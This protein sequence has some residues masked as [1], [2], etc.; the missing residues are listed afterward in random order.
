MERNTQQ[1][2]AILQAFSRNPTPLS[3]HEILLAAKRYA[4]G[5]GIATVYRSI[6]SMLKEGHLVPVKLPGAP[7]RYEP[8]GKLHHH[9]FE[10]K[11]CGRVFEVKRCT[12]NLAHIAPRG[13]RVDRHE[14][15]LYG[16]CKRCLS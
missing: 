5:L 8:A 9:H 14:V 6:K 13:M 7:D 16:T 12:L 11:A 3:P 4:R 10:C 2:R 1:R 15:F